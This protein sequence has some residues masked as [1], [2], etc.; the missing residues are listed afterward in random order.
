MKSVRIGHID[1]KIIVMDKL[2]ASANYGMFVS[3]D[4]EI[5][6]RAGMTPKRTGEVLIHEILHGVVEHQNMQLKDDEERIVTSFA[7]GLAQVIRDNQK[8]FAEILKALK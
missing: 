7:Y 2:T 4:E 3:E 6:L 1:Y 5:Q 8:L